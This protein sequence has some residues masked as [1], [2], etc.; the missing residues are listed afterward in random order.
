MFE[1][2]SLNPSYTCFIVYIVFNI[3]ALQKFRYC[4]PDQA[5]RKRKLKLLKTWAEFHGG[6]LL[7]LIIFQL[8]RISVS[9]IAHLSIS[10]TNEICFNTYVGLFPNRACLVER[11]NWNSALLY[12][13]C[14]DVAYNAITVPAYLLLSYKQQTENPTDHFAHKD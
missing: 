8:L 14:Y 2:A 7:K 1:P 3:S 5:F 13:V 4:I 9:F 12:L 11:M 6:D 10:P